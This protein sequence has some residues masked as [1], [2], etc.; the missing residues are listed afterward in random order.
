MKSISTTQRDTGESESEATLTLLDPSSG[1]YRAAAWAFHWDRK[2]YTRPEAFITRIFR[3]DNP[4]LRRRY[5]QKKREM[6][7]ESEDDE[8]EWGIYFHGTPSRHVDSICERGFLLPSIP[9]MMG[10]SI[11]FAAN[12]CISDLYTDCTRCSQ[13][14]P[15]LTGPPPPPPPTLTSTPSLPPPSPTLTSIPSLPPPP[16]TLTSTPSLPP[17]PP[18]PPTLTSTPSSSPPPCEEDEQHVT[19]SRDTPEPCRHFMFLC[20]VLT[21]DSAPESEEAV[22]EYRYPPRRES[23][24][25]RFFHSLEGEGPLKNE[26]GVFNPDQ[27]LPKFLIEFHHG[28]FPH[29]PERVVTTEWTMRPED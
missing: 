18:P 10:Y 23:D 12:S 5:K 20:H 29:G 24:P 8:A 1:A 7:K 13:P 9:H 27:A 19:G 3:V 25:G 17:P 4:R 21:G 22:H 14:F 16:P 26:V 11:C 2:D 6:K 28:P 15:R